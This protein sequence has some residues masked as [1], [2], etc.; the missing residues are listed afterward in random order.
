MNFLF[1]I[2]ALWRVKRGYEWAIEL[3]KK[4]RDPF[5]KDTN[6]ICFPRVFLHVDVAVLHQDVS[7]S[8]GQKQRAGFNSAKQFYFRPRRWA[9]EAN[10]MGQTI[11]FE[12][13][14][15]YRAEKR[16]SSDARPYFAGRCPFICACIAGWVKATDTTE[17]KNV[18]LQSRI[19]EGKLFCQLC[20][21]GPPGN[22]DTAPIYRNNAQL[23]V[24]YLERSNL[25]VN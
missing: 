15:L 23:V 8:C 22:V 10:K 18:T 7:L 5:K 17:R 13:T 4:W 16:K 25:M 3:D 1:I 2:P 14:A 19:V 11:V 20:R 9:L 21:H 24:V 12:K 6:S